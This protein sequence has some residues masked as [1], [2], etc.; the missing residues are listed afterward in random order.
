MAKEN[1]QG[2]NTPGLRWRLKRRVYNPKSRRYKLYKAAL[3]VIV[4]GVLKS[5]YMSNLHKSLNE[6]VARGKLKKGHVNRILLRFAEDAAREF[7]S[8]GTMREYNTMLQSTD[9]LEVYRRDIHSEI[10]SALKGRGEVELRVDLPWKKGKKVAFGNG[11]VTRII[12]Y[13]RSK[14]KVQIQSLGRR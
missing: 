12:P 9:R 3:P 14:E 2:P 11:K 4:E 7:T 5:E 8:P 10:N 13:K 1:V 6:Q